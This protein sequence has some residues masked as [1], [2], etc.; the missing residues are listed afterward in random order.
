[1]SSEIEAIQTFDTVLSGLDE[2]TRMRVLSWA[3]QKYGTASGPK[4][5]EKAP[6]LYIRKRGT[7]VN[8]NG[9]KRKGTPKSR[10]SIIKDLNLRPNGKKDF[11]SFVAEKQ[12]ADNYEKCT[13]AVYYLN[14]ELGLESVSIDHVFTCYKALGWR[15]PS[16]LHNSLA[17]TSHR[18]GWLDTSDFKNI[19]LTTHGE[20]FVEH[21]LPHK[22][23]NA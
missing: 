2:L 8:V 22:G 17:L 20:N 6:A 16:S 3:W 5:Q 21:D 19:K 18:K 9:T 1:M 23:A 15:L 4:V 12:P 10:P 11:P 7:A 14:Q 13:V